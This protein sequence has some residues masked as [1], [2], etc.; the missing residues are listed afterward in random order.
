MCC[1]FFVTPK[2]EELSPFPVIQAKIDSIF[3][4]R[5]S[6]FHITRFYHARYVP[7]SPLYTGYAIVKSVLSGDTVLLMGSVAVGS[8]SSY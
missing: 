6:L 7:F 5:L 1:L 4:L 8:G 2:I 3:V